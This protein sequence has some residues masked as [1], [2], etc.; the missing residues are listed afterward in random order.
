MYSRRAKCELTCS[1]LAVTKRER[2]RLLRSCYTNSHLP[3]SSFW[4]ACHFQ[5]YFSFFVEGRKKRVEDIFSRIAGVLPV[6]L[7][8]LSGRRSTKRSLRNTY[9]YLEMTAVVIIHCGAF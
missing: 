8:R 4:A 6:M 2:R 1:L 9:Y 5:E 7:R 3:P